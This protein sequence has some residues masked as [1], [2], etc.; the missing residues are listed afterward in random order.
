MHFFIKRIRL[1]NLAHLLPS[2]HLHNSGRSRSR[3]IMRRS[4]IDLYAAE[5]G[6]QGASPEWRASKHPA[7]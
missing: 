3:E 5:K 1:L 4:E 2:H 6:N 7:S